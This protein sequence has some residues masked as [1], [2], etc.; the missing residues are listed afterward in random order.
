MFLE[1][2]GINVSF[3]GRP[4]TFLFIAPNIYNMPPLL[5][6]DI[7]FG[8]ITVQKDDLTSKIWNMRKGR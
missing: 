8:S 5:T 3:S 6:F 1:N 2:C 7:R 4:K